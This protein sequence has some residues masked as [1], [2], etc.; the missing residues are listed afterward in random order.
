MLD[1]DPDKRPDV[2]EIFAYVTNAPKVPC[3]EK[4][5]INSSSKGFL[6]KARTML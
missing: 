3:E 6:S 2:E 5:V 4:T 1:R